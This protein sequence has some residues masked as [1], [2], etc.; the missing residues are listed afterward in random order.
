MVDFANIWEIAFL[1]CKIVP[2][3]VQRILTA[4]MKAIDQG[5][6]MSYRSPYYDQD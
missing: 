4:F 6:K 3:E 5:F 1:K 2:N